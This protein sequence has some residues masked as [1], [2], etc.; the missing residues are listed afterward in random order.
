M[1]AFG[2][3]FFSVQTRIIY[4]CVGSEL[5][6]CWIT[7]N[8]GELNGWA[9]EWRHGVE[10]FSFLRRKSRITIGFKSNL[11]GDFFFA[12]K[13]N[14][15]LSIKNNLKKVSL[16]NSLFKIET[17]S[18]KNKSLLLPKILITTQGRFRLKNNSN[19][20]LEDPISALRR[21]WSCQLQ[22]CPKNIAQSHQ[23]PPKTKNIATYLKPTEKN[24]QKLNWRRSHP[25]IRKAICWTNIEAH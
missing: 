17:I 14:L 12:S 25:S 1:F 19:Q 5:I 3:S 20:K 23:K 18:V 11:L 9:V 21:K 15:K 13:G 2:R 7:E 4:L 6:I 24:L 22:N 8:Q 10:I 16:N